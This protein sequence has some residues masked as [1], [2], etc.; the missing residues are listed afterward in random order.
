MQ[1]RFLYLWYP[2]LATDR[3]IQTRPD[4]DGTN[5]HADKPFATTTSDHRGVF[6]CGLNKAALNEKMHSAMR[7]SDARA[8]YP[9]LITE[10]A[11]EDKDYQFLLHMAQIGDRFSPWIALDGPHPETGEGGLWLDIS[12]AAHLFGGEEA[13]MEDVTRTYS[14][15]NF[16]LRLG[17]ADTASAAWAA[18][19]FNKN[20]GHLKKGHI[21]QETLDYPLHALD[22]EESLIQRLNRLGLKTLADLHQVPRANMTIRFG[23]EVVEKM[24]FLLGYLPVNLPWLHR[25]RIHEEKQFYPDPLGALENVEQAVISLL[26]KLCLRLKDEGLG[27]RRLGLRFQRV[28]NSLI[29]FMIATSAPTSDTLHLMRLLSENLP[30]VDPGFGIEHV[31][32]RALNTQ[33]FHGTQVSLD[34]IKN[35]AQDRSALNTLVDRLRHRIGVRNVSYPA[36]YNSHV[37]ERTVGQNLVN[38]PKNT[39]EPNLPARPIRLL[40]PPEPVEILSLKTNGLPDLFRWRRME[41]HIKHFWGPERITREWWRKLQHDLW[42]IAPGTRDYF[43]T[44]DQTG[45]SLWLCRVI[46][47]NAPP[48]WFVHG[49]FG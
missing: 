16:A 9:N 23:P 1:Q 38:L 7:L 2:Q 3:Y 24:D 42:N 33:N 37:P 8:I 11:D 30:G 48:R 21:R 19:R 20:T 49:W 29:T 17:M 10:D 22:L 40:S 6:L 13:M 43:R 46:S 28:D 39:T 26:E 25:P 27:I 47:E 44:E 32:L 12:G 45:R 31:H 41:L 35:M 34:Q 18:A 5:D 36:H 4:T 14:S 15:F